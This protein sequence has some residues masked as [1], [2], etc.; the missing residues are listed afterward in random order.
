MAELLDIY[1][2]RGRATGR[3]QPRDG[4]TGGENYYLTVRVWVRD[5]AGRL[6]V[7]RRQ[8]DRV[9]RPGAWEVSGGFAQAGESPFAAA[10]R[11]LREET[12]L[13]PGEKDWLRLGRFV[14]ED[15]FSGVPYHAFVDSYLVQLAE[16]QVPITPQASEVSDW[17]WVDGTR[18]AAFE[19]EREME[20]FTAGGFERYRERIL[21][22]IPRRKKP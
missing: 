11:E 4:Q 9:W 17:T 13:T 20:P 21:A 6:L 18:F 3:V 7:T 10:C 1:D 22:G 19:G 8:A 14:Y 5:A 15:V 16:E 2:S 12:G